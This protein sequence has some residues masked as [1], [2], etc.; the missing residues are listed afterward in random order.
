MV[1]YTVD[2]LRSLI[3]NGLCEHLPAGRM[4]SAE[5]LNAAIRY[6]VF[7]GGKRLR[8]VLTLLGARVVRESRTEAIGAACAVEFL[9]ASSLIFDDLPAMDDAEFRRGRAALHVAFG[10][11]VA[12]LAALALLNQSYALFGRSPALI[13]EASACIGANGMIGGQAVDLEARHGVGEASLA[14]RNRKTSS[15]M[16][17]TLT[18]G[19]IACGAEDGDVAALAGA[20][21]FLGEAYQVCD[22]WLDQFASRGESGKDCQQDARHQRLSHATEFGASLC[23]SQASELIARS[24]RCLTERFGCSQPPVRALLEQID[25][26]VREFHSAGLVTACS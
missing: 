9:H 6:A 25:Q 22:D 15:L 1:P 11:D 18:A 8:P 24:K 23:G 20:G 4:G 17:L 5:K 16:R 7:P 21:E 14:V 2:K 13:A 10:E 26:I 3:E 12:L 19:A